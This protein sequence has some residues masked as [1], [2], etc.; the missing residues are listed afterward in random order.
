MQFQKYSFCSFI[1]NSVQKPYSRNQ[2]REFKITTRV[3]ASPCLLP[4]FLV[5]MCPSCFSL[6]RL[7]S[8]AREISGASV[9]AA[10]LRLYWHSIN[11]NVHTFKSILR[12]CLP[13]DKICIKCADLYRGNMVLLT[14]LCQVGK[15][16]LKKRT[17]SY[18]KIMIPFFLSSDV[19][20]SSNFIMTPHFRYLMSC[21]DT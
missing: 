17:T 9:Y 21:L 11:T 16:N 12:M 10:K 13:T 15:V 2:G 8:L 18:N 1:S 4:M 5:M 14:K 20:R 7:P 19:I 3:K 6:S